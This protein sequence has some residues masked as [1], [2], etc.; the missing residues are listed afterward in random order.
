MNVCAMLLQAVWSTGL[1]IGGR[2]GWHVSDPHLMRKWV[3]I[4]FE[5]IVSSR[6]LFAGAGWR[7]LLLA[8]NAKPH[9]NMK[10]QLA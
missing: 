10:V 8:H 7:V 1:L 6:A 5:P 4:S 9:D 3:S 2:R